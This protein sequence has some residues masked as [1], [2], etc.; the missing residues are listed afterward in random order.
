[1]V[2]TPRP[3]VSAD[4]QVAAALDDFIALARSMA[5]RG[6]DGLHLDALHELHAALGAVR[7]SCASTAHQH[8]S[9]RLLLL[10]AE[11]VADVCRPT[12][13]SRNAT[14]LVANLLDGAESVRRRMRLA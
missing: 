14:Q 4:L 11:L 7:T 1:M 13:P 5:G 12:G 9:L 8:A 10:Q 6:L 2:A 3:T